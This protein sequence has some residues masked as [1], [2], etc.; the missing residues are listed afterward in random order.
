[1]SKIDWYLR[2]HLKFKHLQL[3][4]TLDEFRHI[5]KTA[6]YLNISQPAVSRALTSFEEGLGIQI[7]E[8]ITREIKPTEA[9]ECLIRYARFMMEEMINLRKELGNIKNGLSTRISL[10]VLPMVSLTL[11]PELVVKLE[12]DMVSAQV[13]IQ[14]GT[15]DTLL[16]LLKSNAVDFIIGNMNKKPKATDISSEF[17]FQDQM[18]IAVRQSHPL[19]KVQKVQW[20]SLSGYSMILPPEFAISR[21]A[22]EEVLSINNVEFSH[23]Y[24]ESLSALSNIG[25]LLKTD[26]LGFV[27]RSVAQYF[28]ERESIRILPL[29]LQNVTI[30]IGIFWLAEQKLTPSLQKI[31]ELLKLSVPKFNECGQSVR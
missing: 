14:E 10:G 18:C 30:D 24:V 15:S 2:S 29:S 3:L 8:R 9:G 22:I 17:L 31:I 7:F 1:M 12:S 6:E 21:M 27:P 11:I 28:V 16:N 20:S 13:E 19:A 26:A 23:H 5:G 25:I 4:V